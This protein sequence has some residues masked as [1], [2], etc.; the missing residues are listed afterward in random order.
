MFALAGLDKVPLTINLKCD[1][2]RALELRETYGSHI[3]PGY[4]MSKKH[5]NSLILD[6]YL[7]QALVLELIDHSYQL[8]VQSLTKKLQ[9]EL[10]NLE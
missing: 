3:L 9:Q 10:Q 6:G 2:D 8:V 4:H 7:N 5:W 1:P